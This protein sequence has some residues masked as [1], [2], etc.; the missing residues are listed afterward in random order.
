MLINTVILFMRNALPIF[1][2]VS[3]LLVIFPQYRRW[4]WQGLL[5]GCAGVAVL[6]SNIGPI[7]EFAD[8][9][10]FEILESL[11]RVSCYLLAL[12][13]F[14]QGWRYPISSI[15]QN[16]AI[17]LVAMVII[18]N[19]TSFTIYGVGYWSQQTTTLPILLG[20]LLSIGISTS[21]AT[22]LFLALQGR[23]K[24]AM[25]FMLIIFST[26]QL[27]KIVSK[28]EQI[29]WLPSQTPLWDTSFLISN[30][31]EYGHLAAALFGYQANP[32]SFYILIYCVAL[33][34]P[35][36]FYLCSKRFARGISDRGDL[37]S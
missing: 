30:Q 6:F 32:T 27:I 17:L 33:G 1:I 34:I 3:I 37:P 22:L 36:T 28:L 4:I 2:L 10:G 31:S 19:G 21:V 23:S 13:I 9:T 16:L 8:G 15:A 18:I 14:T 25:L 29:N 7:S 5:A 24:S 26:G 12:I 35:V 11:L 20:T